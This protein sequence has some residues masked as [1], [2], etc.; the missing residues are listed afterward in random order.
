MRRP[1]EILFKKAYDRLVSKLCPI[2]VIAIRKVI[3]ASVGGG[4]EIIMIRSFDEL[5][6]SVKGSGARKRAAVAAAHDEHTLQALSAAYTDG[7]TEP[8]LIGEAEK[9]K[10]IIARLNLPF[11]NAPIISAGD[12]AASAREAVALI[13]EREADFIMKGKL[14]TADLLKEVVN[15]ERGL[16]EGGIMSHVG[17]FEI[18]GFH[19]LV[20]ITDG[21][22]VLYPTLEQKTH[23]LENALRTLSRLGYDCPKAAALCATEVVNPKMQESVDAAELKKM[24]EDG[25]LQDCIVEGPISYDLMISCESAEIKGYHSPVTGDADIWLMPNMTCGNILAKALMYSA[26]AKMAGIIVGAKA[27]IVLVSRGATA[28]EKYLSLLLSA[29]VSAG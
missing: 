12:D 16:S 8:I 18:P 28:E 15:K 26:G 29:A 5:K 20:A 6:R 13:R 17:L 7:I 27:P 11:F 24:S 2:C 21:G 1:L 22:M 19:K 25:R 9:I 23:I 14:Q 10:E 4:M 3:A